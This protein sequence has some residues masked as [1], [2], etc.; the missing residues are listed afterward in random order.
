MIVYKNPVLSLSIFMCNSSAHYITVALQYFNTLSQMESLTCQYCKI[1]RGCH[2]SVEGQ[3]AVISFDRNET[4]VTDC[5]A[6]GWKPNCGKLIS[7][8]ISHKQ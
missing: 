8:R 4:G 7:Y 6:P 1:I 3:R 2:V 5:T